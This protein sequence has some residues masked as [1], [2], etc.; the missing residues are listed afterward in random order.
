MSTPRKRSRM[1]ARFAATDSLVIKALITKIAA[2]RFYRSVFCDPSQSPFSGAMTLSFDCDRWLDIMALPDVFKI[3]DNAGVKGSFCCVGKL[4]EMFPRQHK[5]IVLRGH[6]ITNHTYSHPFSEEL[7]PHTRYERLT[8]DQQRS[9]ILKC[10]DTCREFLNYEPVGFRVPHFAVQSMVKTYEILAKAGYT[11]SSSSLAVSSPS[12]GQPY[13]EEYGIVEFP[14]QFVLY[15]PSRH[16]TH[17]TLSGRDSRNTQA[18][19]TS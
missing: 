6:E 16:S 5:E 2:R 17:T 3:L 18:G 8:K 7:N 13:E 15:T 4:I 9:E 19:C 1:F 11:Y 14:F 10:H 12:K